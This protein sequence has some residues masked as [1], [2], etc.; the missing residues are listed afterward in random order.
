MLVS[1]GTAF[2]KAFKDANRQGL[3]KVHGASGTALRLPASRI[4]LL[5]T[6]N[7]RGRNDDCHPLFTDVETEARRGWAIVQGHPGST[8]QSPN[9]HPAQ[10]WSPRALPAGG[11]RCLFQTCL[12]SRLAPP[13][14]EPRLH[15]SR[16]GRRGAVA[17]V[18]IV[19]RVQG[20]EWGHSTPR[21]KPP[22]PRAI[23]SNPET[24]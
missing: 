7:G 17:R 21:A 14:C 11:L 18:R 20:H 12:L 23:N 10:L 24:H 1:Q 2:R 22:N 19:I 6:T 3:H 8:W 15:R 13:L 16:S 4:P 9:S 5:P